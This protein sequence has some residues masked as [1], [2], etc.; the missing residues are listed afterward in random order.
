MLKQQHALGITYVKCGVRAAMVG[1]HSAT[2]LFIR[3]PLFS[4]I[5][6]PSSLTDELLGLI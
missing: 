4:R 3:Q 2:V 5:P 1:G 6:H